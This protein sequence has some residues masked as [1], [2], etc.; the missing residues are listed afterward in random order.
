MRARTRTRVPT[1]AHQKT[2]LPTYPPTHIHTRA[3][4]CTLNSKRTHNTPTRTHIH[5]YTHIYTRTLIYAHTHTHTHTLSHTHTHAD[6]NNSSPL[7]V[8]A[9]RLWDQPAGVCVCGGGGGGDGGGGGGGG[10]PVR[11]QFCARTSCLTFAPLS[12][13]LS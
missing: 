2:D 12:V 7:N 13:C 8:H 4:A 6:P 9:A 5:I 11:V 10:V 3:W 1:L